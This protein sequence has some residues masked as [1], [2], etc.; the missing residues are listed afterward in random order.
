MCGICGQ[1]HADPKRQV[2]RAALERMNETLRHRG[3][4]SGGLYCRGP[5]GLAMRRLAVIDLETGDQPMSNEDGTLWVVLN[6]EIYNYPKLR[7]W[8]E[9]AGHVFSSQADTEV[10]LHL[11]EEHGPGCVSRLRGM[12]AFALWDERRR[13]LLL[14]RD[15]VG[16]KP[17]YY[18]RFRDSLLF[19]SEIKAL[20]AFPGFPRTANLEALHHYLT[21]QYVP[22][23]LSA[24]KNVHKLPPAHRLIFK[25]GRLTIERYWDLTYEPKWH[26]PAPEIKKRLRQVVTEAVRVRL[27][28]DVPLGA[29]LSGGI[30]STLIVGLMARLTA[31]PVKTFSIG[32]KEETFS[33]LAFARLAARTFGTEHHQFILEP[34]V[35]ALLPA[36]VR[37]FDEPFAD[38]AA[39]PTWHLARMTRPHVT[40]ALNGDG[41]DEAFGGYQRYYADVLADA[42]G[43]V[44]SRLREELFDPILQAL[45]TGA[46]RPMERNPIMALRQLAAAARMSHAASVVRW[47]AYFTEADKEALYT[48]DM[49]RAAGQSDSAAFLKESFERALAATRL[50]RTLYTDVNNY[51]PGALLPKVDRT[52]MAHGLEARSPLL[53]QEVLSM[54]ARLPGRWKVRLNQ[55][56]RV[57]REVFADL[58]PRPI[59][60]RGKFGF[61]VPLGQWFRG[62]LLEPATDL[63]LGPQARLLSLFRREPV[64]RLLDE[65]RLGLEDHGKRI[66]ALLFLEVWLR[67]YSP[68]LD[69]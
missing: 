44:P 24:F 51:L 7:P 26:G 17:L 8:L 29:H 5:A 63:L 28:S 56:K 39:L 41:G 54:A 9:A 1:V 2:D 64:A 65:N 37:C 66:F 40:V 55:T 12:F 6:G 61:S 62:P 21:L 57:L 67:E 18:S 47:G 25:N 36:L 34:D 3:P 23:P 42:Y 14:A 52:T 32:F 53:D 10:L 49:Q 31:A 15:R 27:I 58:V 11:Y 22:D 38:P 59:L 33:E 48:P 46:D 69:L 68:S 43:L 4:D 50:D 60:K 19:G 45:P 13:L 16:K 30:D 20:L 35:L